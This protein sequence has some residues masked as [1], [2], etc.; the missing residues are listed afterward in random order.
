MKLLRKLFTREHDEK[1]EVSIVYVFILGKVLGY[2]SYI[3]YLKLTL[4]L[5]RE[6]MGR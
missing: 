3:R 2:N 6:C 4:L 1:D 5:Q